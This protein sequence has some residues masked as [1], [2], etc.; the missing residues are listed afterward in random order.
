MFLHGQNWIYS[1]QS[2]FLFSLWFSY[3]KTS[4][5]VNPIYTLQE[6]TAE[7]GKVLEKY[8]QGFRFHYP[9]S[10]TQTAGFEGSMTLS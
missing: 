6:N 8:F 3:F 9:A 2:V 1:G 7:H 5:L 10:E 4:S